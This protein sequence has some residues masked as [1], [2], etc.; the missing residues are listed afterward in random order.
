MGKTAIILGA[1]G[2]TGGILLQKTL[3]DPS[4]D[5][6]RVFSRS[7]LKQ[8]HP[9][10]LSFIVDLLALE[11]NREKFNADVV[12]CCIGTTKAKTPNT[13]QYR[14]IDYGIPLS[15][16]QLCVENKI[17]SFIVISAMGANISSTVFY[18]RTKGEME[19]DVLELGIKN[20]YILQPSLIGGKRAEKRLG[21]RVAQ[22][23]MKGLGVFIPAKY[24]MIAPTDIV[25][26]M[27]WLA[28]NS[29]E[30]SR[31]ENDII[32]KLARQL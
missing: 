29:Y 19:R 14:D 27:Q 1:T 18:N 21:E 26:C 31:I 4:Y 2:L 20:T 9:K 6:V 3:E 11:E 28:T 23:F 7:P 22:F 8:N 16:A 32:R 17:D 5:Q 30:N 13:K 24:K 10:L 12:F 25:L 15:A